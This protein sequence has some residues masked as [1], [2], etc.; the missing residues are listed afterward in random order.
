[1][2]LKIPVIISGATG[3]VGKN[4]IRLLENHPQFEVVCVAAS[5]RSAGK[6]FE[7]AIEGKYPGYDFSDRIKQLIVHD[8]N[9]VGSLAEK[10]R[11]IFSAFEADSRLSDAEKKKAIQDIEFGY[12]KSGLAVV[13]NNSAHRWTEYVP[14]M[15][16]EI[17][18]HHFEALESQKSHYG[19]DSGFV[20]VKPN[21]SIQS[22]MIPIFA[23]LQAGHSI[24]ELDVT[25]AQA[26][27]GNPSELAY[28][29]LGNRRP[30]ISGEEEK[31]RKE[32]TKIFGNI[33]DGRIINSR[34]FP[35]YAQCTRD[36][37]KNG[38]SAYVKVKLSEKS[39][40]DLEEIINVMQ[41]FRGVPQ[42]LK[43]FYAPSRPII[44]RKEKDRP[45]PELDVMSQRGMAVTVG[46]FNYLDDNHPEIG[47][48]FTGVSHNTIRG[49]A[50]G[51]ILTAELLLAQGYLS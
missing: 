49:A 38:H 44:Y 30:Y 7:E 21:C 12:A 50:G 36:S 27:S 31:T 9:D 28:G 17:N 47:F 8:A 19:F 20:V 42:D 37:V 33:V 15:I 48:Q 26:I 23:L 34:S 11:L 13:S 35:I 29:I 14:M 3:E 46:A 51:A 6:S 25:T 45:Q 18:S 10:G 39:P 40:A 32:P 41:N 22:F 2:G 24:K 16:P 4:F 43:L 5:P 1:M